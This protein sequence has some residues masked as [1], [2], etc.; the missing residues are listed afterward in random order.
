MGEPILA[1]YMSYNMFL[2]KLTFG[3]KLNAPAL[4][5]LLALIFLL[6]INSLIH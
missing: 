6:A 5:F 2:C 4:K 1:I 3:V